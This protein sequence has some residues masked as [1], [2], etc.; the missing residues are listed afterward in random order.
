MPLTAGTSES[1]TASGDWERIA[2]GGQVLVTGTKEPHY[3]FTATNAAPAD[4]F[5]GHPFVAVSPYRYLHDATVPDG[6]YYWIRGYKGA[7]L[8][9]FAT[10]PA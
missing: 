9:G 10:S 1:F 7:E 4:D 8:H 5:I 6:V 2:L 3:A